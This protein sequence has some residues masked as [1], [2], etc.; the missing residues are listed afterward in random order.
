MK[1]YTAEVEFTFKEKVIVRADTTN[2]A[3]EEIENSFGLN[4]GELHTNNDEYIINWDFD[5]HPEQSIKS[6]KFY[7]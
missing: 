7:K 5:M 3:T 2:E 6:I 1:L 4:L